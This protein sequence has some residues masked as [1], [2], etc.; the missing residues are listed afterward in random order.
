MISLLF[1]LSGLTVQPQAPP[2]TLSYF[3]PCY[4]RRVE[5]VVLK[6]DSSPYMKFADVVRQS[7]ELVY[8]KVVSSILSLCEDGK[9]YYSIAVDITEGGYSTF[10]QRI[11]KLKVA[12]FL[13][14]D[15]W[16]QFDYVGMEVIYFLAKTDRPGFYKPLGLQQGAEGRYW[17][18]KDNDVFVNGVGAPLPEHLVKQGRPDPD[19]LASAFVIFRAPFRR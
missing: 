9:R 10:D 16:D 17:K 1:V 3:N 15:C 8:G 14:S 19:Q 5:E 18:R 12:H 6:T 7:D 11:P 4:P 13:C 2:A